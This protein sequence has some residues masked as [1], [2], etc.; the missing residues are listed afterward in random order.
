MFTKIRKATHEQS[1]NFNKEKIQIGP[2]QNHKAG[3]CNN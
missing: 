1:E 3:E 2:N